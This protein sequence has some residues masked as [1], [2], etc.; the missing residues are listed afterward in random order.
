MECHACFATARNTCTKCGNPVCQKHVIDD[1]SQLLCQF[2]RFNGEPGSETWRAAVQDERSDALRQFQ[3][4]LALQRGES[5]ANQEG[6]QL[7]MD[8]CH[9]LFGFLSQL[10]LVPHLTSL[11]VFGLVVMQRLQDI[12]NATS[13]GY[14]MRVM[15]MLAQDPSYL[16]LAIQK[17][18]A[19]S[20][21]TDLSAVKKEWDEQKSE[22]ENP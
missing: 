6:E 10:S 16:E 8:Y 21:R 3:A 19:D 14:A 18:I 4:D 22:R 11:C 12:S 7:L 20:C 13:P 17:I 2:C 5:L 9:S 1:A 15:S